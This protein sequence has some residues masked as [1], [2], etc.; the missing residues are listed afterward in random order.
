MEDLRSLIRDVLSEELARLQ[1][2]A[3]PSTPRVTEEVV[4]IRSSAD[5][6]VFAQ[7]LLGMAQDG[8]VRADIIEGRHRFR[9]SHDGSTP[10]VAHQPMAPSANAPAPAQFVSGMV[11]ERDIA[12]LPDGTRN[13]RAGKAVK[14]TPLARDEMRRRGITV[15]RT[16]S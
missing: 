7:K 13:V 6:N 11:S 5:L 9:L 16:T 4:A 2:E 14:F 12:T 10:I 15:E 8:R 1:P 3:V